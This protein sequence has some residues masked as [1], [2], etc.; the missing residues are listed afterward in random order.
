MNQCLLFSEEIY[1]NNQYQNSKEHSIASNKNLVKDYDQNTKSI[2]WPLS[3]TVFIITGAIWGYVHFLSKKKEEEKI[4]KN[5]KYLDQYAKTYPKLYRLIKYF[6]NDFKT[7]LNILYNKPIKIKV[8]V[9]GKIIYLKFYFDGEFTKLFINGMEWLTEINHLTHVNLHQLLLGLGVIGNDDPIYSTKL[10]NGR[11]YYINDLETPLHED[12]YGKKMEDTLDEIYGQL[13]KYDLQSHLKRMQDVENSIKEIQNCCNKI[14][15]KVNDLE[16]SIKVNKQNVQINVK[17]QKNK[18]NGYP[19]CIFQIDGLDFFKYNYSYS[20]DL[21]TVVENSEHIKQ[22]WEQIFLALGIKNSEDIFQ[23][24][25]K[26]DS[27]LISLSTESIYEKEM[28]SALKEIAEQLK[29]EELKI[30]ELK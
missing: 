3:I 18:K 13:E 27:E 20:N 30:E 21:S 28:S 25:N 5:Q 17:K 24:K 22:D 6:D 29:I 11:P 12:L 16:S 19:E 26:P 2:I 1:N 14:Q 8:V 4:L 10:I 7:L 15:K 9:N 23:W